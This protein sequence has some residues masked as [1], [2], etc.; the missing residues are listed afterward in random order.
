[1]FPVCEGHT[2]P[3]RLEGRPEQQATAAQEPGR[4]GDPGMGCKEFYHFDSWAI[5]AAAALGLESHCSRVGFPGE[6]VC[7]VTCLPLARGEQSSSISP[8]ALGREIGGADTKGR[9]AGS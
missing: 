1:M 7:L 4:L 8:S 6:K 3:H 2:V 5:S 9:G